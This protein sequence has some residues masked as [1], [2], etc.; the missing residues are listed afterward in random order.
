MTNGPRSTGDGEEG[1]GGA[2]AQSSMGV[3][4]GGKA[5]G[6]LV[7]AINANQKAP[8]PDKGRGGRRRGLQVAHISLS[9]RYRAAWNV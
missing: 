6:C 9:R 2:F 1:R 8:S 5:A 3:G 4:G 7:P